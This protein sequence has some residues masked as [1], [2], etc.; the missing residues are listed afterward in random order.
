MVEWVRHA[1]ELLNRTPI[2]LFDIAVLMFSDEQ[3]E[4]VSSQ[5]E[6]FYIPSPDDTGSL[7][8]MVRMM[9]EK[10]M[11]SVNSIVVPPDLIGGKPG[12]LADTIEHVSGC[13]IYRCCL[14]RNEWELRVEEEWFWRCHDAWSS[15]DGSVM[16]AQETRG[17]VEGLRGG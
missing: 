4:T 9:N 2:R 7:S 6:L 13:N 11:L 8:D 12:Y 14:E 16:N 1:A 10:T 3:Y 5:E 15:E 17:Y